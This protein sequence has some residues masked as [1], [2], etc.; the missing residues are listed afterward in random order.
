MPNA[1]QWLPHSTSFSQSLEIKLV[2]ENEQTAVLSP[3]VWSVHRP[4]KV[5]LFLA[6]GLC[7]FAKNGVKRRRRISGRMRSRPCPQAHVPALMM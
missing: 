7:H 1:K 4:F 3:F 2:M 6:I 5:V